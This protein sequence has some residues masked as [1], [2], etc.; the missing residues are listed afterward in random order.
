MNRGSTEA[1]GNLKTALPN[2]ERVKKSQQRSTEVHGVNQ[3]CV[4]KPRGGQRRS[5]EV[6]GG[7]YDDDGDGDDDVHPAVCF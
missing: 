1:N 6:I 7:E 4:S 2:L 3:E 5:T